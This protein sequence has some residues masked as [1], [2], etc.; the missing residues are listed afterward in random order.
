MPYRTLVKSQLLMHI[1]SEEIT[2]KTKILCNSVISLSTCMRKAC[3]YVSITC[4][5]YSLDGMCYVLIENIIIFIANEN[6]F[7]KKNVIIKNF[8]PNLPL[9]M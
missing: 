3:C 6:N 4:I 2:P 5:N 9:K 8:V 1:D 7:S